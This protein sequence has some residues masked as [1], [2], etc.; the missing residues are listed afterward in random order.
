MTANPVQLQQL[1]SV[2]LA[3]FPVTPPTAPPTGS[4]RAARRAGRQLAST[5]TAAST[6]AAEART[7][8]S[9]GATPKSSDDSVRADA[10]SGH[11]AGRQTDRTM[12]AA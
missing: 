1:D 5:L 6:A 11:G 10:D 2:P 8:G 3:V 12:A 4:T 9:Q 7:P